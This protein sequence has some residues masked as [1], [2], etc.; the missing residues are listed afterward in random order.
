[1]FRLPRNED[2]VPPN[3]ICWIMD[4]CLDSGLSPRNLL[5]LAALPQMASHTAIATAVLLPN[6]PNISRSC[7][8][9][10]GLCIMGREPGPLTALL[11]LL[12]QRQAFQWYVIEG[13]TKPKLKTLFDDL[14]KEE[15]GETSN[16]LVIKRVSV[17]A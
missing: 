11:E 12:F 4:P 6:I 5:L 15:L 10:S 13:E 3:P 2:L 16:Q 1:M 17:V 8:E 7:I 9:D 14:F